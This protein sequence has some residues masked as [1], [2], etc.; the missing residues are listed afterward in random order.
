MKCQ[1]M[2]PQGVVALQGQLLVG[3]RRVMGGTRGVTREDSG[4]RGSCRAT[5]RWSAL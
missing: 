2:R 4:E 3:P 1:V 5:A